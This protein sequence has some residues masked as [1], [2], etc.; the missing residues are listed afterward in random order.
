MSAVIPAQPAGVRV[1]DAS[2][3][4]ARLVWRVMRASFAE[5]AT[6]DPPSSA[7]HETVDDVRAHMARGGAVLAYLPGMPDPV[8]SA[9]YR[10]EPDHCFVARVAVLPEYRR[11]GVARALM[12]HLEDIA[13]LH[14][15]SAVHLA[16]RTALVSNL[17]LY[18]SLG[19]E[20]VE[21]R[22]HPRGGAAN[23]ARMVKQ[24]AP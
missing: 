23:S 7:N 6:L 20:V 1:V 4:D 3:E 13:R 21:V 18:A 12:R 15:R 11:R 10:L 19:Y 5:Q 16:V 8:G 2:A 14:R 17:R 9:R 24:L 22:A